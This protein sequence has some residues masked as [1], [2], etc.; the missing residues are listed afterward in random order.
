MD[1]IHIPNAELRSSAELLYELQIS[2]GREPCLTKSKTSNQ[3]TGAVHCTSPT[4][5]KETC[6]DTLSISPSQASFFTQSGKLF[7]PVL[8]MEELCQ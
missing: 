4:S 5:I 1:E 6:A 8:R 2:E 7:L 3:E